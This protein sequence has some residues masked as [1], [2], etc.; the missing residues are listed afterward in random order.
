M[1]ISTFVTTRLHP[2]FFITLAFILGICIQLY[3]GYL[4]ILGLIPLVLMGILARPFSYIT[5]YLLLVSA[6]IAGG[7]CLQI[8]KNAHCALYE[9]TAGQSCDITAQVIDMHP[10][11]HPRFNCCITLATNSIKHSSTN[12]WSF[13][14]YTLQVYCRYQKDLCVGDVIAV[15]NIHFKHITEKTSFN[16]YLT[17]EGIHGTLFMS[18]FIYTLLEHPTKS[19]RR[20]IFQIRQHICDQL[21]KKMP[22]KTYM[23]FASIFLGNKY[24]NKKIFERAKEH[25]TTWGVTHYLARSGLHMVIFVMGW[26]FLLSFLPLPFLFKELLII[27]LSISY[28]LLSWPSISFIRAFLAFFLYKF[29]LLIRQQADVLHV[30]TVV[31]LMILCFN[32]MQL[33]FLDFQLS[34]GLTFALAYFNLLQTHT[35]NRL[36]D[37]TIA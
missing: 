23:L 18:D 29:C 25:F 35:K 34:F 4:H 19:W 13:T 24:C 33:F 28:C 3:S 2:L 32:P 36:L 9:Y 15:N 7:I 22:H 30:L 31:C 1:I 37:K 21:K 20:S 14:K 16:D 12:I 6:Y 17:K 11:D 10:V 27:C 26:H 8:Q 5:F